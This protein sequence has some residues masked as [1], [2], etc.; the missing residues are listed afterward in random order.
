MPRAEFKPFT[1]VEKD[2][3]LKRHREHQEFNFGE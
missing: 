2:E 3:I 1:Q